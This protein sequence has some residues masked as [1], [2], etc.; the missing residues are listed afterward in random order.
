MQIYEYTPGA[1]CSNEK[2]KYDR[3]TVNLNLML[4]KEIPEYH[5]KCDT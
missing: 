2:T 3:M 1:K 5:R 4:P